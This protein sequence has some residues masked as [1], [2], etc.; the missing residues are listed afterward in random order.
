MNY[1]KLKSLLA[2]ITI[3]FTRMHDIANFDIEIIRHDASGFYNV[4]HAL[5]QV[6]RLYPDATQVSDARWLYSICPPS[7]AA[8]V[9]ARHGQSELS[10]DSGVSDEFKGLYVHSSLYRTMLMWLSASY[11]IEVFANIDIVQNEYAALIEPSEAYNI[12]S[13]LA[14]LAI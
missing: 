14:K 1:A 4:T 11:S 3:M 7:M 10:I 9:V 12:A 8:S 2:S 13:E 5:R 6:Y